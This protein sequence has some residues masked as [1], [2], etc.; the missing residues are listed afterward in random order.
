MNKPKKDQVAPYNVWTD[1]TASGREFTHEKFMKHLQE[2]HG[3]DPKT[4]KGQK[5]LVMHV[6][7]DTWFSYQWKWVIAGKEFH[8]HSRSNR[9]GMNRMIWSGEE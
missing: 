7:G 3:I 1:A 4:I 9:S 2:V 5:S 6:D 8:N